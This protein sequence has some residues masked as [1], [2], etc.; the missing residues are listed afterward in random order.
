[1][2]FSSLFKASY[3]SYENGTFPEIITSI[4]FFRYLIL[5][6]AV[7]VN[8]AFVT[9]LERKILGYSQLRKGPN[10]VRIIGLAQPFNDAIKLFSKELIFPSSSNYLQYFISPV[11]GLLI[12]LFTL[13]LFPF[14]E[15][16]VSISLSIIFIYIILSINVYPVLISGW[17]S[18]RKYA[19]LGA[20]RAVAQ[21]V[22]YE[23]S[24]ALI[25]IF[26]LVLRSTLNLLILSSINSIWIKL[27]LFPPMAGIWL[28]SC[29]AETNRTPFDFAEGESELVSGFNVEYGRL[30][31]ALIF[32]AEYARIIIIGLVFSLIFVAEGVR[33]MTIYF[34]I[35][36]L[37]SIWI[38]IRATFP[39]YRYD[40]L[41]NLAWKAY[42]PLSLLTLRLS[43]F[44]LLTL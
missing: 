17:A 11:C 26:Y 27:A 25:L 15:Y 39:R 10:K 1:M 16:T 18:N 36:A 43:V 9:L 19:L 5:V 29:L 40:K 32:M 20:L 34:T 8:V 41:M 3:W 42:L 37:V 13:S 23:V 21:T 31:F 30:G 24:L 28:I 2:Y 6:V 33:R 7:L 22:S 4:R 14:K 12:V 44:L 38:W 35:T